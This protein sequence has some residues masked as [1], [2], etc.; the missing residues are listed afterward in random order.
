MA[1]RGEDI[2]G[3]RIERLI[4]RGGMG[5]V[6]EAVQMS[7]ER[8]VAV[9][10]I[11]PELSSDPGFRERFRRE[12][13][14]AAAIDHPNILPVHEAEETEDGRLLIAMRFVAGR[15]L[16]AHLREFG[17]LSAHA[18]VRLLGPVAD[19]LDAAHA[20]GLVHRDVKP[21]N[22]LLEERPGGVVAYLTDFGL[23]KRVS[24]TSVHT[25]TGK[26]VGTVDYMAPEQARGDVGLD[27]RVD[28][29][30][31]GCLLYSAVT[32]EPPYPREDH[33]AT[34]VAH[35]N[36]PVPVPSRTVPGVPPVIDKVVARAMAKDRDR[37][38]RS[39]GALMRW[40]GGQLGPEPD[41]PRPRSSADDTELLGEE[42]QP[43]RRASTLR[44]VL[45][46]LLILGPLW[47]AAYVIGANL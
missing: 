13:R 19:A 37:R 21:A 17:P 39:A 11:A 24:S 16:G 3:Y 26:V 44:V 27:S 35:V 46:N 7:L 47:A 30:A 12:A 9:K 18:A 41:A 29:Y 25:E 1:D 40:A 43:E 31:F 20:V 32:A 6:Y 23:A 28:V 10:L 38:A 42:P 8:R 33:L 15:D 4:G 34:M 22:V 36:D 45:V 14:I 2:A 5:E